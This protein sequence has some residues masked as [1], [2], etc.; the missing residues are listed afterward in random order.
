MHVTG[1]GRALWQRILM[2]D[3][4]FSFI[5]FAATAGG[6][7]DAGGRIRRITIRR[8]FY[9]LRNHNPSPTTKQHA[10][11]NIELNIVTCPTY[12]DKFTRDMLLHR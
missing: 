11:V 7:T 12:P 10:I 2:R 6:E 5:Q 1:S 9:E 4:V 3:D 8:F